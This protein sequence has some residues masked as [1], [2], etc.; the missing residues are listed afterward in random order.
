VGVALIPACLFVWRPSLQQIEMFRRNVAGSRRTWIIFAAVLI[1]VG[2][3]LLS[4]RSYLFYLPDLRVQLT[5]WRPTQL[6]IRLIYMRSID[7]GEVFLN[8][9]Y[10]KL[11]GLKGVAPLAGI[12]LITI[13]LAGIWRA[14]RNL[15]P[16]RVYLLAYMAIM[17]VWPFGDNRFWLPVLPLLAVV[18]L[19]AMEPLMRHKNIRWIVASYASVYMLMFFI[20]AVYTTRITFSKNFPAT[21]ADGMSE[22]YYVQAWSNGPV[23]TKPARIIRRYG[24]R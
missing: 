21:Y 9:P 12:I 11:R 7:L 16:A 6:I 10:D 1:A 14:R 5:E 24:M 18:G 4:L 17:Y 2:A 20:A 8:V 13:L 15:H 19:E 23:N 3:F 22:S